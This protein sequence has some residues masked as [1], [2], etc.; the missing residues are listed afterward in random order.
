MERFHCITFKNLELR[1]QIHAPK[2]IFTLY[3]GKCI[4]EDPQFEYFHSIE[5][6]K[7]TSFPRPR[8]VSQLSFP[9][10]VSE[11]CK[12]KYYSGGCFI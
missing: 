10:L 12:K 3:F 4:D 5:T 7:V 8:L 9:N 11:F 2:Y 1:L 6:D